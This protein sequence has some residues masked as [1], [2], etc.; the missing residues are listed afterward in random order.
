MSNDFKC[1]LVNS[2]LLT[3]Q[4][5]VFRISCLTNSLCFLWHVQLLSM[6]SRVW[7][8]MLQG[9]VAFSVIL[10]LWRYA[11]HPGCRCLRNTR[12]RTGGVVK[13]ATWGCWLM[14]FHLASDSLLHSSFIWVLN[15]GLQ[16][17]ELPLPCR[18]IGTKSTASTRIYT[19]MP[20]IDGRTQ[21]A[22]APE[23]ENGFLQTRIKLSGKLTGNVKN[24]CIY[25]ARTGNHG[26]G[27]RRVF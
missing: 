23:K 7:S 8:S 24:L 20:W 21:I 17:R 1:L 2:S 9:Q 4:L 10:N 11:L 18:Y 3:G 22:G 5:P 16:A 26:V 14:G 27:I 15:L 19:C 13:W 12:H 6:W 25:A